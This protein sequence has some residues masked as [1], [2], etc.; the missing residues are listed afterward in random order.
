MLYLMKK[1]REDQ[2][3]GDGVRVT[4]FF[5][6]CSHGCKGC[7]NPNTHQ[8]GNGKPFGTFEQAEFFTDLVKDYITGVTFTGGDPLYMENR[9]EIIRL[10]RAIKEVLPDKTIW[11]YTGY[12]FEQVMADETMKGIL[13][14]IDVL[15]DGPFVEAK[16][17]ID[18]H[19][20]G[21]T[22]QRVIDVKAS[23]NE[24]EVV[25]HREKTIGRR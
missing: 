12:T 10:A 18:Y 24:G 20:A 21:S 6:G 2:L 9:A 11:L 5:S 16:K 3:N 7:H 19:W 22:N 23:L 13:D 4:L 1:V 8:Y 14:Y 25:L 15:V 17:D